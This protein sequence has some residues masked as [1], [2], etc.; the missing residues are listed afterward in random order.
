MP[1]MRWAILLAGLIAAA[2]LTGCGS[3]PASFG[4]TGP[5]PPAPPPMAP[6]DA[7]VLPPGIPT[8]GTG[9]GT[10]QRFYNYN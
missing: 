8:P 3:T 6:D 4:I 7:T 1:A 10:E 5:G 2:P 9:S